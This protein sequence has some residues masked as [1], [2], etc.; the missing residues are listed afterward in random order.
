MTLE[1]EQGAADQGHQDARSPRRSP[2]PSPAPPSTTSAR[3]SPAGRGSPPHGAAGTQVKLRFGEILNADGTALHHQPALAPSR[4]TRYTLKGSGTETYEAALH[5]PRLPLR[6]GHRRQ[7]RTRSKAA[8]SP[9]TS[10]SSAPFT[11]SDN[12]LVNQIQSAIRWGQRSNFLG[13]PDRRLPARRAPRLDRRHPGLRLHRRVQRRRDRLPRPVA[14]DAARQPVGRRRL[15]GRRARH[16][17]RRRRRGLGR[18]GHG[19]PVRALPA[20]RRPPHPARELRRDESAGSPTC[21]PTA[22]T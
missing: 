19:R 15:P 2:S 8:S 11:S 9:P 17:L 4:P 6:R 3:T 21:R 10:R 18:R 20:L 7:A 22:A 14:A 12:A 5:L 1:P 13:R 16:L